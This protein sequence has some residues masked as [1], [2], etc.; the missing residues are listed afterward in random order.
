MIELNQIENFGDKPKNSLGGTHSS[1]D[2]DS[3]MSYDFE[4]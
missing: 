2:S 3:L 1:L 4:N